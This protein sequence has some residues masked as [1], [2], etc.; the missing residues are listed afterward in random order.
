MNL[1]TSETEVIIRDDLGKVDGIAVEWESGLIYWTDYIY[2]RIEVAKLNGSSRKTLVFNNL[3]NPRGIAVDPRRGF[4]FWT[5]WEIWNSNIERAD[6][7]GENRQ[8]LVELYSYGIPFSVVIEYEPERIYWMD[9]SH[10]NS[11]DFNGHHRRYVPYIR[12]NINPVDLALYGDN[13]Y[14]VDRNSRSIHWFN[15]TRPVEILSFGHLTDGTLVGVVVSDESR[16]PAA[17]AVNKSSCRL[18]N[19]GCSH[20]C[21]LAPGGRSKCACSNG[22]ALQAD[23][24]TCSNVTQP[25]KPPPPVPDVKVRL[26][27]SSWSHEGRVE[28]YHEGEWGTIC[29]DYWGL[30]EAA[31]V[32]RM[33]NYSKV[34]KVVR[35]A[36]YGR[37]HSSFPIWMDN[38]KCRGDEQ[39][40]A[41][42]RHNGWNVHDCNHN[43]DAGIVC[44][45]DSIPPTEGPTLSPGPHP[46]L[47]V[48]LQSGKTINQG[49][50]ELF[51]NNTWGTICDDHWGIEEANVICRML[52]YSEGAWS[53]PCCDWFRG[54]DVPR[55][56]WLDD[57]HCVGDEQSVAECRHG[58]W[59]KHNCGH[60]DDVGV[61]CKYTP[62]PTP[63]TM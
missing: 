49:R 25:G 14:W 39:T 3:T 26:R 37:V 31:V 12:E 28:V 11:A 33:L 36:Y 59:G 50:V 27:G 4:M 61:V 43:K 57:V 42:C 44:K 60:G 5:D 16:Q 35:G 54:F 2:E 46:V 18:N 23:N 13:L 21:L 47:K 38:V 58:G 41:A 55:K 32:C 1:D 51:L 30:K 29:N 62:I 40:I 52:N 19:G 10:G 7:T 22:V 17:S 63:A 20:L 15:K 8:T 6:L 45:N 24:K 56:I 9:K 48:R 53:A 34:V